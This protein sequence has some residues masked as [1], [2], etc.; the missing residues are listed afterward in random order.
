MG[1]TDVVDEINSINC[2]VLF[3]PIGGTYTMDYKEAA[4]YTNNIKPKVVIPIHYGSI[5]GDINLGE[6][7][8][9]M[10]D[11]KIEVLLKLGD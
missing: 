5:V 8:K 11:D 3:V 4:E 1:D 10:V 2:D 9:K 7:F 6:E